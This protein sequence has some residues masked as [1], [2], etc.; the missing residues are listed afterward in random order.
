MNDL[1]WVKNLPRDIQLHIISFLDIDLRR[2]LGVFNRINASHITDF[3]LQYN[4]IPKI[5]HAKFD[6]SYE[7]CVD[8]GLYQ[9]VRLYLQDQRI[10]YYLI[11]DRER[12]IYFQS[13]TYN[14]Y[15]NIHTIQRA[16]ELPYLYFFN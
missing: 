3:A 6:A 15:T 14:I 13:H 8:L 9:M 7:A 5:M 12:L 11:E 16:I 4:K 10:L 1:S 2:A